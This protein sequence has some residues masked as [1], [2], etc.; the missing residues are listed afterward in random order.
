MHCV[1][2]REEYLKDPCACLSLPHWK[3]KTTPVPGSMRIIRDRDFSPDCLESYSDETYGTTS[4]GLDKP[5]RLD[6]V[7]K[8]PALLL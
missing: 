8:P 6:F 2:T 5:R 1:M 7:W 4:K 3:A